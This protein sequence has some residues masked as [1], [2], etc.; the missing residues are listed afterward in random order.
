[1][2]LRFI[3]HTLKSGGGEVYFVEQSGYI[4]EDLKGKPE[5]TMVN[6]N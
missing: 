6:V 4:L 1:V 5:V 2:V 3:T